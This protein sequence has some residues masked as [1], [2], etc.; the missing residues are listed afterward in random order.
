MQN[1][2][3]KAWPLETVILRLS[4]EKAIFTICLSV[5]SYNLIAFMKYVSNS[6]NCLGVFLLSDFLADKENIWE[7]FWCGVEAR[8]VTDCLHHGVKT[9]HPQL[10]SR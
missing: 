4:A 1:S 7:T 6:S 3:T 8:V 10:S 9:T 2:C 5:A